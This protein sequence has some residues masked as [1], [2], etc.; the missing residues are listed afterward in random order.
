MKCP[1]FFDPRGRPQSQPVVIT[2]FTQSVRP[3]VPKLQN[4]ATITAGWDCGLAE[5]IIDDSC[6][7]NYLHLILS[8]IS[9]DWVS[10]SKLEAT[11]EY[12]PALWRVTLC[13]TRLCPAIRMPLVCSWL[14]MMSCRSN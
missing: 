1:V 3:S 8:S 6:F 4:Q 10:P 12:F 11:Q 5:W 13:N 7:V 2:I 9:L 14:T